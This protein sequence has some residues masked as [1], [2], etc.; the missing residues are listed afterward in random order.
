[1]RRQ[2]WIAALLGGGG[3]RRSNRAA[4]AMELSR[5]MASA[6]AVSASEIPAGRRIHLQGIL[7]RNTPHLSSKIFLPIFNFSR[8]YDLDL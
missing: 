3:G 5:Q 7:A 6:T 4:R 8:P 2:W 1:M